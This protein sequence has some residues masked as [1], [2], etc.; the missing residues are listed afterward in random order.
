MAV[1]RKATMATSW[2]RRGTETAQRGVVVAF[3][4]HLPGDGLAD[5]KQRHQ[6]GKGAEEEKGH[7]FEV[8]ATLGAR[9]C[10]ADVVDVAGAREDLAVPDGMRARFER[11]PV[12][13]AVAE[14]DADEVDVSDM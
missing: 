9:R 4:Q 12:G 8:D 5:E 1:A 2:A 3:E 6:G 10:G 13:R 11:F 7:D 14:A